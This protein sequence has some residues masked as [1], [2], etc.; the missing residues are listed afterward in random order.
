MLLI[1]MSS[2]LLYKNKIGEETWVMVLFGGF[3]E[4]AIEIIA[5]VGLLTTP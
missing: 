4:L 2:F 5:C 3:L 1:L